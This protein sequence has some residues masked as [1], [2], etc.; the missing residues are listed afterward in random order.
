MTENYSKYGKILIKGSVAVSL[1]EAGSKVIGILLLP[2]F[3]HFLSPEDFGIISMITVIIGTLALFYNPGMQTATI[4]LYHSTNSIDEKKELIGSTY[5][6]YITISALGLFLG[7]LFGP[8]VFRKMFHEF[9]FYPYG[10]I[11]FMLAFLL[12]PKKIWMAVMVLNYKIHI[13]ALYSFIA[14]LLG[15]LVSVFL[16]VVLKMGVMGRIF[17]MFPP[18]LLFFFLSIVMVKY[19]SNGLWSMRSIKK[20]LIFGFPL[21]LAIVSSQGLVIGGPYILETMTDLKSVGLYSIAYSLASVPL[22]LFMGVKQQLAP[23]FL[24]NMNNKDFNV[25]SK[26]S[27]GYIFILTLLIVSCILFNKEIVIIIVNPRYFGIIAIIPIL[28]SGFFFNGLLVL[29]NSILIYENKLGLISRI[30]IAVFIVYSVLNILLIPVF[31]VGGAALSILGAYFLYFL[32]S[33]YINF[34]SLSLFVSNISLLAS[35]IIVVTALITNYFFNVIWLFQINTVEL[36]VK[37]LVTLLACS[38]LFKFCNYNIIQLFTTLKTT[39]KS[40]F[41]K[42]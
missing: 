37:V 23:I 27:N 38:V 34:K 31:G 3:T 12:Q 20:Q 24:E 13:T 40:F 1:A 29:T 6:F 14:V 26:L 4:R 22:M 15:L 7:V 41:E 11:A 2:V 32:I 42:K 36:I 19:Y 18:A 8:F 10:F 17:G 21:M 35:I 9:Q 33:F 5:I 30:S 28:V 25:L 16:V 39:L